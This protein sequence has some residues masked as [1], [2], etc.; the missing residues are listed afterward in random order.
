MGPAGRAWRPEMK[1]SSGPCSA[2][3]RAV[4]K[5]AIS[6]ANQDARERAS[7]ELDAESP[8]TVMYIPSTRTGVQRR[9][10]ADHGCVKCYCCGDSGKARM[11]A[12]R[13]ADVAIVGAGILGPRPC[14]LC[15]ET[16]AIGRRV[17]AHSQSAGRVGAQLRHDLA[18]RATRRRVHQMAMRSRQIWKEILDASGLPYRPTGSLH[19]VYHQD[20]ADVAQRVR[21]TRAGARLH[22]HAGF[23]PPTC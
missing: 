11:S 3:S 17:R 22:V 19:V 7:T 16:R 2:R 1:E 9:R 14:V 4:A 20:E 18:D 10:S 13:K 23:R 6:A 15:R 12:N 21:R 5:A 8:H